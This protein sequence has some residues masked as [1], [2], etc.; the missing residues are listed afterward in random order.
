MGQE[1]TGKQKVFVDAY[2]SNGFNATEAARTAG[3]KGGDNVYTKPYPDANSNPDP[4]AD[5]LTL[6]GGE[7]VSGARGL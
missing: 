4:V 7:S 3:Y 5:S 6:S 1:L 2:L